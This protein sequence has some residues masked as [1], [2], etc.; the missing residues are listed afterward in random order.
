MD[1]TKKDPEVVT[2]PLELGVGV[3]EVAPEKISFGK[4]LLYHLW[5]SDQHLKSPQVHLKP[6]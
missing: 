1:A 6:A 2:A 5:D 4:K 3:M